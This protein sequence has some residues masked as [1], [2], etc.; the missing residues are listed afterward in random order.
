MFADLDLI[1]IPY[2]L[3]I[4][5]LSLG[6][7]GCEF[8]RRGGERSESRVLPFDEAIKALTADG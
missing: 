1:G 7:G 5:P 3:V 8:S 6:R 4:S 2:R